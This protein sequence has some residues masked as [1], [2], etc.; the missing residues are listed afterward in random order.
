MEIKHFDDSKRGHFKAV[1]NDR[2]IGLMD[3][4]WAGEDKFIIEHTEADPAYKG[5]GVG[6]KLLNKAVQYARDKGVKIIP[7]CPFAKKMFDRNEDI[8]DVL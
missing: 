3:Y 5:E 4:V 7:L 1:D 8:R 2:Q 6:M